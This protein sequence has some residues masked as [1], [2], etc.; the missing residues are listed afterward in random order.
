MVDNWQNLVKHLVKKYPGTHAPKKM[1]NAQGIAFDDVIT[2]VALW[3][4]RT[5][6]ASHT[7][8]GI[9]QGKV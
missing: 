2:Q 9:A 6:T 4:T 5:D 7:L 8:H 3:R 1:W